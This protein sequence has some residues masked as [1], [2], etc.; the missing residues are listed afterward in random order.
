MYES[1]SGGGSAHI[2]LGQV[3]R[4]TPA[5]ALKVF[6][7]PSWS[8]STVKTQIT[9]FQTILGHYID[10]FLTSSADE[11]SKHQLLRGRQK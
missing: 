9:V 4:E 1:T 8:S 11:M 6:A 2:H 3:L 10:C 5:N 7:V